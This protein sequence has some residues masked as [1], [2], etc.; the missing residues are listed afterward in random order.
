M[1]A[2][3]ESFKVY[4]GATLLYTSPTFATNEVRTIEQCLSASTNNQYT[5]QL[6]DSYGDSWSSLAFLTIYGKYGNV[7]FK[8]TMTDKQFDELS[9]SMHYA[10]AQGETWKMVS[11]SIT[12]GWTAY[13]FSD[14][15]WSDATLGA[16]TVSA[17][18][19]QY[20]R[21]QF[22]GLSSM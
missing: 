6:S 3:E 13:S 5:L 12:D 15:T 10:I 14:T 9:L 4:N 7:F 22:V 2:S 11:G 8:A 18:G 1:Y 19:S 21:K 16:V 20:F 17:A